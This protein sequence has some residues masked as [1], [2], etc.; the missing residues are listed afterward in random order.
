MIYVE[1]T[2]GWYSRS[3]ASLET[4]HTRRKH[5][6]LPD[7]PDRDLYSNDIDLSDV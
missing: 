3:L 4:V 6:N 7:L 1:A 5:R 2:V